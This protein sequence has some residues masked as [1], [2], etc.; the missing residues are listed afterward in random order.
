M[1]EYSFKL[2]DDTEMKFSVDPDRTEPLVDPA[3][4]PEWCNLDYEKCS[5]CPLD[6]AAYPY[7]PLAANIYNIVQRFDGLNSYDEITVE[8]VTEQVL[9]ELADLVVDR[10]KNVRA[11]VEAIAIDLHGS[12]Q[13]TG[14]G[15]ALVDLPL[16]LAGVL[17]RVG[18][19]EP[20]QSSAQNDVASFRHQCGKLSSTVWPSVSN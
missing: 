10:E 12:R 6:A 17:E 2:D 13:A 20:G 3:S 9:D 14:F 19:G 4:A 18:G 5:N 1:I 11:V 8:V 7:C 15:V 16:G